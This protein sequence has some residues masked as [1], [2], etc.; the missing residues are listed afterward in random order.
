MTIAHIWHISTAIFSYE[1][2]VANHLLKLLA[3]I[4]FSVGQMDIPM[5]NKDCQSTESN[6]TIITEGKETKHF[7]HNKNHSSDDK[8]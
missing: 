3:S 5:P 1:D 7:F 8:T 2:Y 6:C 4:L